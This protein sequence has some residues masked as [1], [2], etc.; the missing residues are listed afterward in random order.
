MKEVITR[1][2]PLE[3]KKKPFVDE[4]DHETKPHWVEP[5]LV[6]NFKFATWTASGKIRKPAIFLG[7]RNDKDAKEVVREIPL[8]SKEES[9]VVKEKVSTIVAKE[10]QQEANPSKTSI[11]ETASDSNWLEL[12]KIEITS[13]DVFE[14]EGKQVTLTNV[15]R[16]LWPGITKAHL[17]QYY[18]AVAPYI[19]P[20]LVNRPQSLHIK[21]KAVNA[22]GLYIKDMEGRQPEWAEIFS[23]PRKHKKKGKRDIIDYLVCN[24]EATL[25][26]MINL[27]CIDINPWTSRTDDYQQPDFIIIDLDPSDNDFQKVIETAKAAKQFFDEHKLKAFPKTSGKTGMHLY[28]PC[29]GFTFSQARKIAEHICKEVSNLLPEITTTEVSISKRGDKLFVDFSQNDEADTVAAPYSVRPFHHPAVSTPLDWKEV[30]N[31]LNT[32]D[33]DITN[34]IDRIEKKGDLFNKVM[35]EK[36]AQGNSKILHEFL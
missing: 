35:D 22:P 33:F 18:H 2:K 26:Y 15:E 29:R 16:E 27:G 6:G 10:K 17:I 12:E 21:H 13:S 4:V 24:D 25:L 23:T 1:L 34:I 9:D 11:G 32:L 7:F 8:N 14:I 36:I 5:E 30:N 31:K 20:Y 28:V 19:M 3:I